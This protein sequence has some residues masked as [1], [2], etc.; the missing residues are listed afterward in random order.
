MPPGISQSP[1]FPV[2]L[3]L[4]GIGYSAIKGALGGSLQ[5][6]AVAE[7]GIQVDQYKDSILY[8]GDSIAAKIRV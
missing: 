4:G 8:K 6:S 2:E 5:I 1:R 7:V 3:N